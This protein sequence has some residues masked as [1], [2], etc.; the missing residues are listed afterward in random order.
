MK[1]KQQRREEAEDR[2][3]EYD[4]LT[5]KEKLAVIKKRRG[6]SERET[7]RLMKGQKL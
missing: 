3:G 4:Y 5:T 6:K 7:K 1:G 2:Q